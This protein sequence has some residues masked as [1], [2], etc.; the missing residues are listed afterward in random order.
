MKNM[1]HRALDVILASRAIVSRRILRRLIAMKPNFWEPLLPHMGT[2]CRRGSTVGSSR[3]GRTR[4][5]RCITRWRWWGGRCSG[6]TTGG[7][8]ALVRAALGAAAR[9]A[10]GSRGRGEQEGVITGDID[11]DIRHEHWDGDRVDVFAEFVRHDVRRRGD[12]G[13]AST[14]ERAGVCHGCRFRVAVQWHRDDPV[15]AVRIYGVGFSATM[16]TVLAAA[17]AASAVSMAL[18]LHVT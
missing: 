10:G 5:W 13:A 2:V 6:R 11:G 1:F 3:S 17:V 8:F 15:R 7:A 12:D 9:A 18:I 14:D 4:I 16:R